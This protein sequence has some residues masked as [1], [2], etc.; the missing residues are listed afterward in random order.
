[1]TKRTIFVGLLTVVAVAGLLD[2]GRAQTFEFSS[3]SS[4]SI[5]GTTIEAGD[6]VSGTVTFAYDENGE[7]IGS[8]F[9]VT[10]HTQ[11]GDYTIS[12]NPDYGCSYGWSN[13]NPNFN[14]VGWNVF[15][16]YDGYIFSGEWSS[17][18]IVEMQAGMDGF[19]A[20]LKPGSFGEEPPASINAEDLLYCNFSLEMHLHFGGGNWHT[21][22]FSIDPFTLELHRIEKV[23][24]LAQKV[25]SLN[26][27]KG[28]SNSLDAK[29]DSALNTLDDLNE[30]NDNAAINALQAFINAVNAQRGKEL[31]ETEADELI[32]A[33]QDIID[34]IS[35]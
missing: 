14:L 18:G 11:S 8:S 5:W 24:A 34:Q 16:L 35:S 4:G 2:V 31:T 19:W 1:M 15:G 13:S 6:P 22:I 32:A 27:Q 33:A 28:I 17:T 3:A 9:S 20:Y 10:C 29:L 23:K 7:D 26:L 30:K 25:V 21:S 12:T